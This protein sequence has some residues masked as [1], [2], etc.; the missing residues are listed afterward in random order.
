MCQ[1]KI[2]YLHP[3]LPIL[4]LLPL[5]LPLTLQCQFLKVH[6]RKK[7]EVHLRFQGAVSI[8]QEEIPGLMYM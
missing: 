6:E 1:S 8:Q 7:A 3:Y 4:P 2:L 5:K